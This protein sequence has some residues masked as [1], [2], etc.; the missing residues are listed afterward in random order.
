V[1]FYALCRRAVAIREQYAELER[2]TYGRE[3]SGEELAL[4]FVGDVGD[5][6]KLI[7]AKEGAREMDDLDAR[8]AHELVDCLWSVVVLA[9]RYGV[10]LEQAFGATMDDL[11]ASIAADL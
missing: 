2:R 6:A 10:D 11:E 4:G 7:S 9:E 3:W 8:L 1:E 5:L